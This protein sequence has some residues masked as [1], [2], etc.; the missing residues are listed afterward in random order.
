[1]T[2]NNIMEKKEQLKVLRVSELSHRVAKMNA[3]Q[4]G[5]KLQLYIEN[6]IK[7]DQEGKVDWE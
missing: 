2:K 7:K 1:L 6:L 3:A 4:K 5:E